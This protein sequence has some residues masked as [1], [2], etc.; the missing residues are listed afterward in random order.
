MTRYNRTLWDRLFG[1][2]AAEQPVGAVYQRAGELDDEP[3]G[4]ADAAALNE[5]VPDLEWAG[6]ER[7]KEG[8]G[9]QGCARGQGRYVAGRPG[10]EGEANAQNQHRT[11]AQHEPFE[12]LR[13]DGHDHPAVEG[14]DGGPEE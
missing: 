14:H 9:G 12:A 11:A 13:L 10:A 1:R 6:G 3:D 2:L 8:P 7:G 4:I 5:G